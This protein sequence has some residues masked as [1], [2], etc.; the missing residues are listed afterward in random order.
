MVVLAPTVYSHYREYGI[1]Q[2]SGRGIAV[3]GGHDISIVRNNIE[4]GTSVNAGI[5]LVADKG[6]KTY[7]FHGI[8]VHGNTIIDRVRQV[9]FWCPT[10]MIRRL[11]Q[12]S[13]YGIFL[14]T[15]TLFTSL[16]SDAIVLTGLRKGQGIRVSNNQ[17]YIRYNSLINDSSGAEL[18][19]NRVDFSGAYHMDAG[20]AS[21]GSGGT[22]PVVSKHVISLSLSGDSLPLTVPVGRLPSMGRKFKATRK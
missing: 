12:S 4:V 9:V 21:K 2:Q 1:K 3:A 16:S 20:N 5:M 6:F 10:Y 11:R 19:D 22:L 7:G 18:S 15:T 17:I 13:K 8:I 14:S